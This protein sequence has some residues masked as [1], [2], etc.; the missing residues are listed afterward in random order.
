ML[1]LKITVT[2]TDLAEAINNLAKALTD[3]ITAPI[4]A[5]NVTAGGSQPAAETTPKQSGAASASPVQTITS[6]AAN[7]AAPVPT[8]AAPTPQ[9]TVTPTVPVF[10]YYSVCAFTDLFISCHHDV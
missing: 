3:N 10:F 1:E 8:A 2:A 4:K 7:T 6:N 9:P 5:S